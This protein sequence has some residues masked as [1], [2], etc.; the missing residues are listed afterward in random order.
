MDTPRPQ[1]LDFQFHQNN[2]SFPVCWFVRVGP[3]RLCACTPRAF[4]WRSAMSYSMPVALWLGEPI[5][6]S[7]ETALH[8]DALGEW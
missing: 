1:L 2:D 6:S 8:K 7:H 4:R 5:R 3:G